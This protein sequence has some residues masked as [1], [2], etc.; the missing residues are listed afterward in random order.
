ME[1][2]EN[3]F[4]SKKFNFL[5][6]SLSKIYGNFSISG[7]L[8]KILMFIIYLILKFYYKLNSFFI[9]GLQF[10]TNYTKNFT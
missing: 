7:T 5:K 2:I 1:K 6:L 3:Q 10:L 8:I 4:P 9:I